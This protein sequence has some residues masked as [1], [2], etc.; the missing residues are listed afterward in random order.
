MSNRVEIK[1]QVLE[2]LKLRTLSGSVNNSVAEYKGPS[3]T[4]NL[5]TT[6]YMSPELELERQE[7]DFKVRITGYRH[8]DMVQLLFI[9]RNS[10]PKKFNFFTT[11]PVLL[12][13]KTADS[14]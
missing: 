6:L 10:D 8:P 4:H 9:C 1:L 14:S 11:R 13:N 12:C 5:G 3:M 7:Y 2:L